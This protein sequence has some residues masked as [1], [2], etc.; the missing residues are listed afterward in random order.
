MGHGNGWSVKKMHGQKIKQ[1]LVN[2]MVVGGGVG[3]FCS[4][5]EFEGGLLKIQN[6]GN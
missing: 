6:L 4:L 2:V 3:L 1:K 5:I